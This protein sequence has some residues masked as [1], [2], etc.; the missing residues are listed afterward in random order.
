MEERLKIKI[1]DGR[2]SSWSIRNISQD[3]RLMIILIVS[4]L[5]ST[6][7]IS[8]RSDSGVNYDMINICPPICKVGGNKEAYGI[9]SSKHL[10]NLCKF[11]CGDNGSGGPPPSPPYNANMHDKP[12]Q[13]YPS[14][15]HQEQSNQYNEYNSGHAQHYY[16]EQHQQQ[17]PPD[18]PPPRGNMGGM[19]NRSPYSPPSLP[20]NHGHSMQPPPQLPGGNTPIHDESTSQQPPASSEMSSSNNSGGL[21]LTQFDKDM[22]FGGL[23][24]M[25][26]KKILPLELSSKFGHFH[27][28]PLSPSDFEAKPM[29][30]LLGQYSVG[31]TSFIKYLLGRDFPGIR[32]GPEPTTDRFVSVM[33]GDQDKVIPGAALC[34]QVKHLLF[35]FCHS[36]FYYFTQTF[37][38]IDFGNIQKM[39]KCIIHMKGQ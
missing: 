1:V 2:S 11:R 8:V 33:L 29:V 26:K 9:S 10:Q 16:H 28:P 12:Y 37:G 5:A 35:H 34:S 14:Q 36:C 21:D 32:I 24:R 27:S 39:T 17:D 13:S 15:Q 31:K 38:F 6:Q 19:E 7:I 4:L 18:L 30:L 25:Y 3:F 20:N 23:K 22:I